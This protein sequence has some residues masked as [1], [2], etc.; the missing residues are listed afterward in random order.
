MDHYQCMGDEQD[1]NMNEP[2]KERMT[3]PTAKDIEKASEYLKKFM[4]MKPIEMNEGEW[5][6]H[7]FMC[8]F[9][10]GL[11]YGRKESKL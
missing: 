3:P 8:G 9:Y 6:V 4:D 2:A 7:C 11:D 10:R 5:T 1:I